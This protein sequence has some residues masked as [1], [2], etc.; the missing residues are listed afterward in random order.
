MIGAADCLFGIAYTIYFLASIAYG[1]NLFAKGTDWSLAAW[2]LAVAGWL[3]HTGA[4]A[5]LGI[6]KH[7]APFTTFFESVS[8]MA[9]SVVLAYLLVDRRGKAPALGAFALPLAFLTIFVAS[10]QPPYGA[11]PLVTRDHSLKIHIAMSLLGYGSLAL[12]FCAAVAYLV[13][14]RRL[15]QKRLGLLSRLISLDEADS[16]ANSLA[17]VGFALLTLG[18]ITGFIFAY[19]DWRGLWAL[20]PKVVTSLAGWA[21]YAAYLYAHNVKGWRGRKTMFLLVVGFCVVAAGFV[22]VNVAGVGRHVYRPGA[23]GGDGL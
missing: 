5:L 6:A 22:G 17:A 9:W 16:L 15:K 4:L 10:T 14:E 11:D 1:A 2:A 7:H 21:V 8:F 20:D 19:R 12:A 23:F 13:Q 3:A 18:L